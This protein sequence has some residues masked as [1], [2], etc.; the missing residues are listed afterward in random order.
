M[1]GALLNSLRRRRRFKLSVCLP[2]TYHYISSCVIILFVRR[3][4]ISR[5]LIYG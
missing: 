2:F 3:I 4:L 1:L 5:G